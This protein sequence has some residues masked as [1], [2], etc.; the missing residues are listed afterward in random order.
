M[1]VISNIVHEPYLAHWCLRCLKPSMVFETSS[2]LIPLTFHID[3]ISK[4]NGLI[5]NSSQAIR[6]H[7][8]STSFLLSPPFD[9]QFQA[10]LA[11]ALS[12][13]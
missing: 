1:E 3:M 11:P 7:L 9:Q 2:P 4:P 13:H 5:S 12:P 10:S 8:Q 6:D